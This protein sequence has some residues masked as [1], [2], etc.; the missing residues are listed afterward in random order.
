[1]KVALCLSG[2]LRKFDQTYPSL[3]KYFLD[4]YD[5]DIFIH[6][7]D[8]LG[9]QSNFR[10]DQIINNT[11]DRINDINFLFKPKKI[12]VEHSSF[13]DELR[14]EANIYAPH[15]VTQPK[16]AHHM[17]SMFYKIY[18]CNEL[19]KHYQLETN[20]EYDWVVRSRTDLLFH[21]NVT[22][23]EHD[24]E[25]KIFMPR[26][27]FH[28]HWYNDQFAIASPNNMDVY[29]SAFFDIPEYFHI[30]EEYYPEKFMMWSL[31]KKDFTAEWCDGHFSILR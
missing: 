8:K 23:P 11:N 7:W 2:H 5:C 3:Q 27:T 4:R 30:R 10:K 12:I 1:M 6:T 25:N 21:G 19:R 28:S 15:L 18:A 13:I 20:V 17:A 24:I 14:K 26:S 16:P 22:I 31:N 9:Y 29:S